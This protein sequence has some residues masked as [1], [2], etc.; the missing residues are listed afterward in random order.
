MQLRA[1]ATL[2]S[3][4]ERRTLWI[5]LTLKL[6]STTSKWERDCWFCFL[7]VGPTVLLLQE[8]KQ[9]PDLSWLSI[10]LLRGK[11]VPFSQARIYWGQ[12][13]WP[14]LA[15]A[16]DSADKQPPTLAGTASW[17]NQKNLAISWSV[18]NSKSDN[19]P[20]PPTIQLHPA[21]PG[22][23]RNPLPTLDAVPSQGDG[24]HLPDL[25]RSTTVSPPH[26]RD[27]IKT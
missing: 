12:D 17:G 7:M 8:A 4:W 15:P 14:P 10:L 20:P 2:G 9:D 1:Y 18:L 3:R 25:S 16:A 21:Q 23:H 27:L 22:L 11:I 19:E 5:N 6:Q 26:S 24:S 13:L